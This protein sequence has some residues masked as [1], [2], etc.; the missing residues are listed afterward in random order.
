MSHAI[1]VYW[2][3]FA[4]CDKFFTNVLILEHQQTDL[5]LVR[6]EANTWWVD[7]RKASISSSKKSVADYSPKNKTLLHS[8]SALLDVLSS[9]KT[10]NVYF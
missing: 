1:L 6:F 5:T 8:A 9:P 10:E 3:F 7:G 2:T 4:F